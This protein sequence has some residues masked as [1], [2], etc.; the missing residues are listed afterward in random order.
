MAV[1][2]A[3]ILG[4]VGAGAGISVAAGAAIGTAA[5]IGGASVAGSLYSQHKARGAARDARA[6]DNKRARLQSGRAAIANV[7]QAQMA[8]QSVVQQ[9]ENQGVG[10]SSAI[11]GATGSITSQAGGNLGFANTIFGLQQSANR[12]RE[13]SLMWQGRASGISQLGNLGMQFASAGAT[14]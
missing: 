6:V 8:R 3:Y 4:G 11:A 10:S 9:G 5:V 2:G 1:V 7:R 12:L 13:S 14:A